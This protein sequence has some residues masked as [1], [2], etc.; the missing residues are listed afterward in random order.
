M[1]KALVLSGG[2][3]AGIAWEIALAA[4]RPAGGLD[5]READFI[6]GTSAGSFVGA[7]LALGGDPGELARR[8]REAARASRSQ[9]PAGAAGADSGEQWQRCWSS[10]RRC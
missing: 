6:T 3:V 2:G 8:Q 1:T 4:G 7:Q 5:V 9:S 10:S